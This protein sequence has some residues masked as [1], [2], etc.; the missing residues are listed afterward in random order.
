MDILMPRAIPAIL[1]F[2]L[3]LYTSFPCAAASPPLVLHADTASARLAGHID[4]LE[5]KTGTMTINEVSSPEADKQFKPPVK[6]RGFASRV[7]WLRFTIKNEAEAE[8]R[9]LLELEIPNV[10]YIDLYVPTTDGG[11][12]HML[13]GTMRPM[14]IRTFQHR[15]PVFSVVV[16][17]PGRTFYLRG[18]GDRSALLS[19]TA[20]SSEAFTRMDHRRDLIAGCYFGAMLVMFAYNLFIFL[21]L[22]DRAYLYYILDILCFA[23]YVLFS[24]GFLVEL[25]S[26]DMAWIFNYTI[27]LALLPMLTGMVFGRN[28]L[29]TARNVPFIDRIL[30]LFMLVV[31]LLIPAQ[32]VVPSEWLVRA[33][34]IIAPVGSLL[35]LIAGIV[36]LYRGYRPARYFI[37]ARIFRVFGLITFV[38]ATNYILP[39]NLLSMSSLQIGSI[40]EVLML[41]FALADR[42]TILRR[43]KEE[44]E[45]ESLKAARESEQRAVELAKEMTVE[46]REALAGEQRALER[47]N[48]FMAMLS[49]EYRTPLAIIRANLDL[50]ELKEAEGG[51]NH[52]SGL[53]TMKHAVGRLVEVMEV[54]MQK[55]RLNGFHQS[56]AMERIN[57]VPFLDAIIDNAEGLWPERFFVFQ[58]EMAEAAIMGEFG[59][60]KTAI[61]NL[62]DNACKYSPSDEP[63]TLECRVDK[64]MATMVVRDRGK[65]INPGE[66][67]KAFEKYY[68]GASS[69]DTSGAGVGL[70][71]VRQ[72]VE[73]LGGTVS[74]ERCDGGGTAA[75]V[76]LPLA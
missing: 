30:K 75:T 34:T 10:K 38:L 24:K 37:A 58:P 63:V 47:Q 50:M 6:S 1:L 44:A 46:L 5:D 65:G 23:L 32:F 45:T 56:G 54:S 35:L 16:D 53:N 71:L 33:V 52:Q 64:G 2:F 70:W 12:N 11:Y 48:R 31:I 19:L 74:L 62:L 43:E 69:S 41:S 14:N 72:I 20:W 57:L 17:G 15:N 27:I 42:I 28:F 22:R 25:V 18:V 67:D 29:A 39:W 36:C 73:Q 4:I 40:I 8:Q 7:Y 26:A 3:I 68:R 76:C 61:F 51:D 21:S 13:S 55:E 60:L 66:A 59:V 49:H 9:W